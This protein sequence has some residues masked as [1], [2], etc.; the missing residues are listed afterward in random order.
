[1]GSTK[2]FDQLYAHKVSV[3]EM[4]SIYAKDYSYV[5]TVDKSEIQAYLIQYRGKH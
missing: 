5:P 2:G 4:D 3:T 1:M